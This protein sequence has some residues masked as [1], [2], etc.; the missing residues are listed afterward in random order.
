MATRKRSAALAFSSS[1]SSGNGD[2]SSASSKR[3]QFTKATFEKWQREHQREHQTLSWL[4][5]LLCRD[6]L[7]VEILYCEVYRKYEA[8]LCSLRN[9]SNSW[10]K[11][12]AN[13]KLSNML[14]HARSDVH[15]A[16]MSKL[17]ADMAKESGESTLLHT[18]LGRCVVNLDEEALG[19]LKLKFNICYMM[20]KQ[21]LPFCKVSN[22]VGASSSSWS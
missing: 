10:I 8:R 15:L 3:R 4:R 6:K 9:F 16:A 1:S 20:A 18:P 22:T 17:R 12:P 13:L 14:D 21:S 11:G 5:C 19:R 2:L 7:H